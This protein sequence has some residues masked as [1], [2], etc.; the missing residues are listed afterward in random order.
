VKL[1]AVVVAEARKKRLAG[2]VRGLGTRSLFDGTIHSA[3]FPS[4]FATSW[5]LATS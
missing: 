4:S 3:D 1:H 5:P 2:A